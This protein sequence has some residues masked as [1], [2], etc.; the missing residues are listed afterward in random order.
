MWLFDSDREYSD[1]TA[2]HSMHR[3]RDLM[4]WLLVGYTIVIAAFRSIV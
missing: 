3:W 1:E 2:R 4:M